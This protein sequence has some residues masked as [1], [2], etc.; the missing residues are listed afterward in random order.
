MRELCRDYYANNAI[1]RDG[2]LSTRAVLVKRRTRNRETWREAQ[3]A[4][5]LKSPRKVVVHR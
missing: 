2:Y 5:V 1:G 4:R 3:S